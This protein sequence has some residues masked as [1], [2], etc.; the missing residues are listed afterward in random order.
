MKNPV[1]ESPTSMLPTLVAAEEFTSIELTVPVKF[2]V[3][4]AA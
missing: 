2:T 3:I 1:N 4:V